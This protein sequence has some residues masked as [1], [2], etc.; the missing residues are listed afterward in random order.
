M[1]AF[2]GAAAA[3]IT[4]RGPGNPGKGEGTWAASYS[5]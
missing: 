5:Q 1:A 3:K 4:I 2:A